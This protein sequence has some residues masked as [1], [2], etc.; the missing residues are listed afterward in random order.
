[1]RQ[2]APGHR[3]WKV[4]GLCCF[5]S[6]CSSFVSL[7]SYFASLSGRAAFCS[8][9]LGLYTV[10]PFSNPSMILRGQLSM[11]LSSES[12]RGVVVPLPWGKLCTKTT[13]PL[14]ILYFSRGGSFVLTRTYGIVQVCILHVHGVE[15]NCICSGMYSGLI[16]WEKPVKS[17]NK[18]S[19]MHIYIYIY[20]THTSILHSQLYW[21]QRAAKHMV[22]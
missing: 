3:H 22:C 11:T 4:L 15:I 20:K 17:K 10:E 19:K 6:L 2:W 14:Q 12:E 7:S 13:L 5:S 16:N 8:G 9:D 18:T 1:M 21:A